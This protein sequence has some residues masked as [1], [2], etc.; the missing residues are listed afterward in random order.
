[1]PDDPKPT[2]DE[3]KTFVLNNNQNTWPAWMSL[4]VSALVTVTLAYS[5]FKQVVVPPAPAPVVVVEPVKFDVADAIATLNGIRLNAERTKL[6]VDL[7]N[8]GEGQFILRYQPV[9]KAEITRSVVVSGG[10]VPPVPPKPIDPPVPPGPKPDDNPPIP[11][12]G[13]RVM[14]V[15]ENNPKT[16]A[17]RMTKEQQAILGSPSIR[18]YLDSKCPKGQD[19]K[20][21]EWRLFEQHDDLSNETNV[22]KLAMQMPRQSLPWIVISDGKTGFSGPLPKTE[23]ETLA[24]LKTYGGN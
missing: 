16:E 9:G 21:P 8:A 14:I 2:V 23:A 7:V 6:L 5:Q 19:G 3:P 22:W 24:L 10:V 12:E 20:T 1:M 11:N 15:Y 17:E 18:A 4:A 13:F